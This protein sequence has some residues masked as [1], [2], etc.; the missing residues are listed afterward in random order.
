[1]AMS[2]ETPSQETSVVQLTP[3]GRG[4]V[5]SLLVEGGRALSVIESL[6]CPAGKIRLGSR[7]VGNIA[8]GRWGKAS[9]DA[10]DRNAEDGSA[11]DGEELVVCR[12]GP[13]R[14]E[15]HCHGGAAAAG[16]IVASLVEEGCRQVD[17]T[18]WMVAEEEDA[19]RSAARHALSQA[20][21]AR[22]AAIL[23]DQFHGAL[24]RAIR[25]VIGALEQDDTQ[26]AGELLAELLR[27]APVGRHLTQPWRVVL[28]GRPNVGKSSLI[29]AL[30]GFDRSI[31][32]DQPGT[33]RD[34]VTSHTAIDGWP[35]EL[36]DTAGLRLAE[37]LSSGDD[38]ASIEAAGIDLASQ[39]IRAADLVV[40]VTDASQ[41]DG[42]DKVF[43]ETDR[44]QIGTTLPCFPDS[45][46]WV[47]NKIDTLDAGSRMPDGVL[48]T[49]A[50]TGSGLEELM[51]T[52]SERLVSEVP[53]SGAA[54]LFTEEQFETI[55]Q[56][57]DSLRSE[58]AERTR[59]LL[60]QMF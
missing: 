22:T 26:R 43:S 40:Y 54:V 38:Q 12:R 45:I 19:I 20:T 46:L 52:I 2:Q 5:A 14:F 9:S 37:E 60:E 41:V 35:V 58:N 7:K 29:N 1:M 25:E 4:A 49:S 53:P 16:A 6:F 11:K 39:R 33:T 23:L 24:R 18:D 8:F 3:A 10:E 44:S 13:Q 48:G 30:V 36:A 42:Q 55:S 17:W 32:F 47:A 21:T 56:A 34:V 28:S 50:T 57:R 27:Y 59:L 51:V 31:V 15:I